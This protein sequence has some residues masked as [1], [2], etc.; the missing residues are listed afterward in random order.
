ALAGA[1][2][3]LGFIALLRVFSIAIALLQYYG[4][5]LEEHG[6]RLTVERGLLTRLRTSASRRRIQ[7]F[8]LH[9]GLLHRLLKRR[10]LEVETAV[11]GNQNDRRSLRELA[12]IAP[13]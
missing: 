12:P 5:R 8:T 11:S 3:V 2:L 10:A 6:R 13:P 7:A 4:F 1:S 9:E